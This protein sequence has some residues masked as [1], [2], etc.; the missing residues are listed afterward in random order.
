MHWQN[1]NHH[2]NF[3]RRSL[4]FYAPSIVRNADTSAHAA[5]ITTKPIIAQRK[6]SCA[7]R[8]F[9]GSPAD[10]KKRNPLYTISNIRIGTANVKSTR[11]RSSTSSGKLEI[12]MGLGISIRII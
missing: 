3:E 9:P 11:R 12:F 10:V 1:V 4:L 2:S 8:R 5:R 6:T 7:L